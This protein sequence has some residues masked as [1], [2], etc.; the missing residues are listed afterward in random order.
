MTSLHDRLLANI[1]QRDLRNLTAEQVDQW[2][3]YIASKDKKEARD[4]QR[5]TEAQCNRAEAQVRGKPLPLSER[6]KRMLANA[7]ILDRIGRA[8]VTLQENADIGADV[9]AMLQYD[10]ARGIV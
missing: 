1:D 3:R 9:I 7:T 8:A 10:I 2:V 5:I 4:W 6:D